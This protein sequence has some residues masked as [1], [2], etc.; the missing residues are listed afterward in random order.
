MNSNKFKIFQFDESIIQNILRKI[1]M[2]FNIPYVQYPIS[3][4]FLCFYQNELNVFSGISRN[5]MK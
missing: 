5:M 2:I 1:A 4:C 3:Y